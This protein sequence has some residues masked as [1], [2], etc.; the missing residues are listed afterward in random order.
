MLILAGAGNKATLEDDFTDME[1]IKMK[2]RCHCMPGK[3]GAGLHG[4]FEVSK[5]VTA[6]T[7][8]K[9]VGGPSLGS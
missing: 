9:R 4:P 3:P 1:A 2:S 6:G 5:P 7:K 8:K